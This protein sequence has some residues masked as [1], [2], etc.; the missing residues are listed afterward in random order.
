MTD[1]NYWLVGASWGGTDHQDQKFVKQGMWMLGWEEKDQPAQYKKAT[2]MRV[3]DRIAIKPNSGGKK[4]SIRVFH[5]GIIKGV[6]LETNKIICTV[7][8]VASDLNRTLGESKGAYK[9]IND[10]SKHSKWVE[11]LFA[12]S[13][14]SNR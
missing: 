13:F 10:L 8:W 5:L 3:W 12:C 9:S 6:I 4:T 7:N 1:I 11:N 2:Q 14:L